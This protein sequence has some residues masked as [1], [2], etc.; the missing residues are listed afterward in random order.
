MSRLFHVFTAGARTKYTLSSKS[1]SSTTSPTDVFTTTT[2]D[3][4]GDNDN[5]TVVFSIANNCYL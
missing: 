1:I 4:D 2:D 3:D 5:D